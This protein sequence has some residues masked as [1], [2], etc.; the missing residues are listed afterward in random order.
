MTR[1]GFLTAPHLPE[2]THDDKLVIPYL[3]AKGLEVVPVLWT[4]ARPENLE[5]LIVRSTWAYYE[6]PERFETWLKSLAD[7]KIPVFNPPAM[8]LDNLH[9]AYLLRLSERGWPVVPTELIQPGLDLTEMVRHLMQVH[10]WSDVILKPELSASGHATHRLRTG[11]V[12]PTDL[13]HLLARGRTLMLQ[14]FCS[15]IHSEGEWSLLFFGGVFSHAVLKTP[16]SAH[17]LVQEE[18]G[19]RTRAAAPPPDLLEMARALVTQECADSLYARVDC[20]FYAD[21]Y[22]LMELELLEPSL[23]LVH[24]HNAPAR[25]AQAVQEGLE[26][27]TNGHRT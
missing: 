10:Q 7:L 22:C 18:H 9:K 2:L 11:D 16:D 5:A 3:Q 1:I 25:W 23:Y 17:H 4:E 12:I 26:K 20:V 21:R 6:Q 27:R 19:G 8:L 14:P 13:E 24:E 15:H